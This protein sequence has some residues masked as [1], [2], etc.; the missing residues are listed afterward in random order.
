MVKFENPNVDL[1]LSVFELSFHTVWANLGSFQQH[2]MTPVLW[3]IA[4]NAS[5]LTNDYDFK[6]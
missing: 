1:P 4:I 5:L 2:E 3:C 6:R